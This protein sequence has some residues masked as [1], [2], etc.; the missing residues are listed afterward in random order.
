MTIPFSIRIILGKLLFATGILASTLLAGGLTWAGLEAA[1]Y[2][3]PRYTNERFDGLVC[4]PLMTRGETGLVRVTV[5]NPSAREISPIITLNISAPGLP[6]TKKAQVVVAAGQEQHLAWILAPANI[7]RRYFIFVKA[8]RSPSH[9]LPN[10]EATCG[11]LV[12]DV[13]IMHGNQVLGL[14]L[15]LSLIPTPL[16]LWVWRSG[17]DHAQ[18]TPG[19]A[20]ALAVASLGGLI[21]SLN[22][23]WV[24][25]VLFLVVIVLLT[26]GLLRR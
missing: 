25:G 14:W 23:A 21:A 6:E 20:T 12:L 19:I 15:A 13:P 9:P 10:A 1:F 3:F 4:P 7:D 26:V 22:G 16:G 8:N 11:T 5:R 17:L 18:R 24:P 2:G